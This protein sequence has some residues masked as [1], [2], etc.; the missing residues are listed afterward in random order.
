V[1]GAKRYGLTLIKVPPE[2]RNKFRALSRPET[3]KEVRPG[4]VGQRVAYSVEMT[5]AEYEQA[6]RDAENPRS[7]LLVI[8]EV[9]RCPPPTSVPGKLILDYIAAAGIVQWGWGGEGVVIALLDTGIS[10]AV[11]DTIFAGRI[12]SAISVIEGLSP[13]E[14]DTSHGTF[15]A[16]LVAPPKAH[17][18]I[19]RTGDGSGSYDDDVAKG[20]YL[21]IDENQAPGRNV[22][23]IAAVVQMNDTTLLKDAAAE[24]VAQGKLVFA[25][26]GNGG[27]DFVGAGENYNRYPAAYPGILAISN[28]DPRTDAKSD[29]SNY[30]NHL[31][32]AAPGDATTSY[33]MDGSL[34]YRERGGTSAATPVA[35]RV[36]AYL[37]TK[38]AHGASR[39]S[40]NA[41]KRYL[42]DTARRTGASPLYEGHGVLQVAA[43]LNK[44]RYDTGDSAVESP[45]RGEGWPCPIIAAQLSE[46]GR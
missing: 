9:R 6:R 11:A 7:N 16:G 45:E 18:S 32:A 36:A 40:P 30:G 13:Y 1:S 35:T 41:V 34:E 42:A 37:L 10:Q 17:L 5:E 39:W 19:I 20:L 29:S 3:Y 31:F 27:P 21:A 43:A 44:L 28:Y 14:G 2:Q 46:E 23:L 15:S 22:D 33:A 26:A 24:A 8:E 38:N 4:E 12:D 25:A